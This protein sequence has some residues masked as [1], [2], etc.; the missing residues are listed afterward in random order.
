MAE[1]QKLLYD[2][3]IFMKRNFYCHE[4]TFVKIYSNVCKALFYNTQSIGIIGVK[5]ALRIL[6][7]A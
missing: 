3:I 4:N 6:F 1:V 5:V 2:V 7:I